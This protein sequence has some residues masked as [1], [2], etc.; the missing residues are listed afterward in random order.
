MT[1]SSSGLFGKSDTHRLRFFAIRKPDLSFHVGRTGPQ[2]DETVDVG[3]PLC[4]ID[5]D[6]EAAVVTSP[7]KAE[8]PVTA[9]APA[10]V[11]SPEPVAVAASAPSPPSVVSSPAAAV[12]TSRVPSIKF[13][14]KDGW[15]T[16]LAGHPPPQVVYDIPANYGRLKFTD[17]EMEAL[18]TGGANMAP[19]IKQYSGGARFST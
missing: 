18:V 19:E 7:S 4:E 15:A 16:A 9:A 5:T 3:A 6:V 11:Q 14:G 2:R 1:T 8:A 13:R 12:A 10:A 17:D